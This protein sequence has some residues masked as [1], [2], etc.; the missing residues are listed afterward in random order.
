MTIPLRRVQM[1]MEA[2]QHA[3]LAEVASREGKSLAEV[4]RYVITL[5][6]KQ[7]SQQDA[8]ARR[9]RALQRA[10]DLAARIRARNG[11]PL[12]DE[13]VETLQ[14]LREERDEQLAGGH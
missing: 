14:Q 2:E 9:A 3:A 6:L 1:L 13:V 11:G 4:T 12:K 5:G 7:L 10:D 8:L